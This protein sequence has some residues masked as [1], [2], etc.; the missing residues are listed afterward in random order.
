[1]VEQKLPGGT[2][3]RLLSFQS[4]ADYADRI[5]T[6]AEQ[7]ARGIREALEERAS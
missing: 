2:G 4:V 3:A 5:A 7:R 6:E 1:V